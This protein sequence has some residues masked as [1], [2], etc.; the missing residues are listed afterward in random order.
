V[1]PYWLLFSLCAAG[2]LESRRRLSRAYQGGP[3]LMLAGLV[4]A[5]M[6]GLRLEV[7]ADWHNYM[8]IFDVLRYADVK[9]GISYQD[10]GYTILNWLAQRLGAG[11]WFVN[12][13]CAMLF[14]WGL[15][16][17]AR[18]QPNPWLVMVVAVPYLVIVVAMGYTRQA[19]A[20][21]LLLAGLA[22]IHQ[23]SIF[24]FGVYIAFAALFHKSAI[25]VLPLVGLSVVRQRG[26]AALM[27]LVLGIFLYYAVL[28]S[29]LDTL[30]SNYEEARLES[31]GAGIRVAMNLVPAVLFLL[32]GKRF[33]LHPDEM[34]LW[35]IFSFAALA[36]LPLLFL[37][38]SSTAVDRLALYLLP[39]QLFVLA[40]LPFALSPTV[41]ANGQV[42]LLVIAYSALVQFIWLNYAANAANW[43]PYKAYWLSEAAR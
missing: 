22:G 43:I 38:E 27:I 14:T 4:V 36:M 25:V 17:F 13:I 28:Q 11:I 12:L 2:A 7:G 1:L 39:L 29:A 9:D 8:E 10:P 26:P 3:L 37:L 16:R 6:V 32:F 35:R 24:R 33:G 30:M 5:L 42:V 40:R 23:H 21:G 15:V 18:T 34:R 19:V 20:I 41:R 31:E